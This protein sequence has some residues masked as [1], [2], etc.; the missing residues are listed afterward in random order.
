MGRPRKEIDQKQF[1]SLCALQCTKVEI[2]AFLRSR[3]K[4]WTP[5]AGAHTESV[6]PRFSKKKVQR[7]NIPAPEP[8]ATG[9][10]I[11]GNGHIPWQAVPGANRNADSGRTAGD[12]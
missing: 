6:F 8:M 4:R 11:H 7:E 1:E 12:G 10:K 9:R 3:I 2:C 5:G